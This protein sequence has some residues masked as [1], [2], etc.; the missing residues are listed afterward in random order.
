MKAQVREALVR[1]A[2]EIVRESKL[3]KV[4]KRGAAKQLTNTH[5]SRGLSTNF[6][7]KAGKKW[8]SD[9][10]F[11]VLADASTRNAAL[12]AFQ[13]KAA[14]DGHQL[15]V[16]AGPAGGCPKCAPWVG[17]VLSLTGDTGHPTVDEAMGYGLF[18]PRCR[19]HLVPYQPQKEKKK[20]E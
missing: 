3:R 4:T 8:K 14:A 18:H 11:K 20:K 5:V 16:V 19:H 17:M 1:D 10:Y 7:D 2:R 13:D 6:S 12:N 15:V 9:T